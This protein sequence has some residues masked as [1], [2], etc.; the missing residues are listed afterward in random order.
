M[1]WFAADGSTSAASGRA[2]IE[3]ALHAE[4]ERILVDA[5]V[6]RILAEGEAAAAM[7]S[8]TAPAVLVQAVAAQGQR[9]RD[10]GARNADVVAR[11]RGGCGPPGKALL[12]HCRSWLR[13]DFGAQRNRDG[14]SSGTIFWLKR[15][16]SLP[17]PAGRWSCGRPI[18]PTGRSSIL[19]SDDAH[20]QGKLGL[21]ALP[22]VNA[23]S[24]AAEE[25]LDQVRRGHRGA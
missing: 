11:R 19:S 23:L 25:A 21:L 9:H 6:E 17:M 15:R 2:N 16:K 5:D 22:R 13:L 7:I 1:P 18:R 12:N 8:R 4:V 3:I 10:A 14:R 24:H 20:D